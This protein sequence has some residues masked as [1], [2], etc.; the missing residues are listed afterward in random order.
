M[1]CCS[2]WD[3]TEDGDKVNGECPDCGEDTVDGD[4]AYGCTYS[5]VQCKTCGSAPCDLSC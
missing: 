4:A 3:L 1:G 2:P 5:P